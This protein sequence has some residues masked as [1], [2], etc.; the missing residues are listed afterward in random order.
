MGG[1]TQSS[2]KSDQQVTAVF[3]FWVELD[4]VLVGGFSEVTG[5]ESRLETEE[6][7]EGGLN[8]YVHV[9]PKGKRNTPLVF[10]RGI[11]KSSALWDWYMCEQ[12]DPKKRK[13][14]SVILLSY[15]GEEVCRWNFFD[16][17]PVRWSGPDLKS[18]GNAVAV[19]AIEIVHK[20][21]K[22]TFTQ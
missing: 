6:Y 2:Q 4:G 17:Y 15:A 12:K 8:D 11:T 14:G 21:L 10:K 16:S 5:L 18:D 3:R 19:E 22:V 7:R 9:L 1:K 13:N 20:G